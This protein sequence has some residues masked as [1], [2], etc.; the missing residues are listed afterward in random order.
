MDLRVSKDNG[1]ANGSHWENKAKGLSQPGYQRTLISFA[2]I[3]KTPCGKKSRGG[4]CVFTDQ[5]KPH[6]HEGGGSWE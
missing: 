1:E 5:D 3:Q 2:V 6:F 4:F